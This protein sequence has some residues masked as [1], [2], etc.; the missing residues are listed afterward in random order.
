MRLQCATSIQEG[1]ELLKQIANEQDEA[2][3][4]DK[5]LNAFS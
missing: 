5:Y 2:Q 3:V 1:G 4:F